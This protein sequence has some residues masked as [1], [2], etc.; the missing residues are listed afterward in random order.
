MNNKEIATVIIPFLVLFF[1]IT[2]QVYSKIRDKNKFLRSKYKLF[3]ILLL[4]LKNELSELNTYFENEVIPSL[5]RNSSKSV[6]IQISSHTGGIISRITKLSFEDIHRAFIKFKKVNSN[7]YF[8][9]IYKEVDFVADFFDNCKVTIKNYQKS[10]L[11]VKT[12]FID[13]LNE[14]VKFNGELISQLATRDKT[15]K[16]D[17]YIRFYNQLFQD[18]KL[19]N[20]P[21]D[22]EYHFQEYILPLFEE[23]ESEFRQEAFSH[24]I[25][26]RYNVL[27]QLFDEITEIGLTYSLQFK[28]FS[29]DLKNSIAELNKEKAHNMH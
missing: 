27:K 4:E 26:A 28:I 1:T 10:I 22:L 3:H 20:N 7:E 18:Y 17:L 5:N 13:E 23:V 16:E 29:D 15:Q 11:Q 19:N 24:I 12:K 9:T 2:Y 8:K 6:H 21:V 25:I 14:L